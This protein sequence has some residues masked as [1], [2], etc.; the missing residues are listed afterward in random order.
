VGE[1]LAG[2][3]DGELAGAREVGL[4][5]LAG[6]VSLGEHD[7][8]LASLGGTPRPHEALQRAQ[9]PRRVAV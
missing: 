5:G 3:G 4:R 7:L 9:L 8:A 6:S 2:D 1:G